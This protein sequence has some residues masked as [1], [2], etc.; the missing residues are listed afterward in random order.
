MDEIVIKMKQEAV[1][2][3]GIT[4]LAVQ[5][6]YNPAYIRVAIHRN[7]QKAL[8]RILTEMRKLKK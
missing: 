6:G 7:N 3:G 5:L 1:P 4:K 8:L 2:F